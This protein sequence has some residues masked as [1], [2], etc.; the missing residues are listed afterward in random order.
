MTKR[1]NSSPLFVPGL[2]NSYIEKHKEGDGYIETVNQ[3]I[4]S[5]NKLVG[6]L[7]TTYRW[8]FR[9]VE[10]FRTEMK[11][12]EKRRASPG[13]INRFYWTDALGSCQAYT[14]MSVW[15][16]V[17]LSRSTVYALRKKDSVAAAII[18]RSA[19]ENVAQY[20]DTA[21]TIAATFDRMNSCDFSQH[22]I[23]SKDIEELILKT[24][25]ASRLKDSEDYY[26]PINIVT[27]INRI[28]KIQTQNRVLEQYSKLCEVTHPNFLGRSVYLS[29]M[30]PGTREGD[31]I[32]EISL[33]Q[34]PSSFQITSTTIWVL[35]WAMATQVSSADLMQ[36]SLKSLWSRLP[37]E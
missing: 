28:S 4:R 32:R 15:R 30:E 3:N 14:V 37:A 26:K 12:L 21:R 9:T 23:T 25:F 29:S 22:V 36:S 16:M 18:A 35:S 13:M 20:L 2:P 7:P 34:G 31:E 5:F 27:I 19:M 8:H 1:N 17:E 10:A 6:M 33:S 11:N 24:V